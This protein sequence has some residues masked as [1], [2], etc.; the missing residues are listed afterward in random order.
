M[1]LAVER[2]PEP[3]EFRGAL[4]EGPCRSRA[5]SSTAVARWLR[6]SECAAKRPCSG[7]GARWPSC[8]QSRRSGGSGEQE[9]KQGKRSRARS[10]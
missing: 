2:E 6:R 7:N 8:A 9:G 3:L 1:E 4:L 10:P 5:A